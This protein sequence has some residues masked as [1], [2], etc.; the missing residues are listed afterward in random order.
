MNPN[1]SRASTDDPHRRIEALLQQFQP[2]P[3]QASM[4]ETFYQAGLAAA[5]TSVGAPQRSMTFLNRSFFYGITSG[6]AACLLTW[7]SIREQ[8]PMP[9][10]PLIVTNQVIAPDARKPTSAEKSSREPIESETATADARPLETPP[11]DG[12]SSVTLSWLLPWPTG[13]RDDELRVL[14]SLRVEGGTLDNTLSMMQ[15]LQW[16]RTRKASEPYATRSASTVVANQAIATPGP[17][18]SSAPR[19]TPAGSDLQTIWRSLQDDELIW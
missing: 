2:V 13:P 7:L 19:Q 17:D 16:N 9:T 10:Q 1:E 8:A 14:R 15:A 11:R 3:T 18:H 4:A 6:V 12:S 5:S